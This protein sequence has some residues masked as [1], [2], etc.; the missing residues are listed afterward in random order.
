MPRSLIVPVLCHL[1]S[2]ANAAH[3][4]L[5]MGLHRVITI[6]EAVVD[7]NDAPHPHRRHI[8]NSMLA[9]YGL[10]KKSACLRFLASATARASEAF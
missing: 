3:F 8:L 6:A 2:T 10:A 4:G 1:E 9:P 7:L 5:A